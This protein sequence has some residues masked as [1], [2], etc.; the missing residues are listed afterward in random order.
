M[1]R[2]VYLKMNIQKTHIKYVFNILGILP[3]VE[4]I[5][6]NLKKVKNRKIN[7]KFKKENPS[8]ILP[9]D[10]CMYETFALDYY[11]IY[12]GGLEA[13]KWIVSHFEKYISFQD[14]HLLDWGCGSSRIIRHLPG[15]I[16]ESN[17]IYGTD[18]NRDYVQW[19]QE[20]IE[21]IEIKQN[22][23][24]PPLPFKSNFFDAIYGIS[25]F[26]H[27]SKQMHFDW[28][29]ELY[30]VA[31]NKAIVI[32][33]THGDCFETK[34]SRS[35]RQLFNTGELIEHAYKVEGNR[36]YA[37]YQSSLFFKKLCST[38]G[39]KILEHI[40]GE[41]KNNKPQQDVWI[42]QKNN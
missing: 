37:S 31:N 10:F 40:E 11:K 15:L 1:F 30:R 8:I 32:L 42:L 12:Y 41:N 28:I 5:S 34:L 29:K 14:K 24:S 19:G 9:P 26:T 21:G 18:Y 17:K 13:A 23:L 6:F 7:K 36:L 39:F 16:H 2:F 22:E 25:I 20:N 3:L 33:T 27:L 4:I 38:N 35:E